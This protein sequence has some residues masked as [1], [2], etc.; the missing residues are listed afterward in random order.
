MHGVVLARGIF[1]LFLAFVVW[2]PGLQE[3]SWLLG[4]G[5]TQGGGQLTPTPGIVTF[6]FSV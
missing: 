3:L 1:V 6:V 4:V 5:W 2:Y